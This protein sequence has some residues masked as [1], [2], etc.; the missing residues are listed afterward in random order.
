VGSLEERVAVITGAGRGLGREHARLFASEGARVVV[1][2]LGEVAEETAA[3]IRDAGGQAIASNHDITDWDGGRELIESALSAFGRLDVLVN[4]A[5]TTSFIPHHDLDAVTTETWHT[6]MGVNLIG[7]PRT[8]QGPDTARMEALAR[9]FRPRI[10]FTNSVLHNPT[11]TCI[12]ASV[13]HRVLRIAEEH[14]FFVCE[15][16]V[17]G[18]LHPGP[19]HRIAELDQLRRVVYVGGFSKTLGAGL[20]VG[21]V[22]AEREI[23]KEL[24]H[25]KMLAS[26]ATPEMVERLVE[27]F[28]P[29]RVYLFG[30]AARGDAGPDSDYDLLVV[31]SASDEPG[32]RRMQRAQEALWGIWAAADVF[33]LTRDEFAR[34]QSV[35]TSLASAALAEGRVLYA[36]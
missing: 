10:F 7:V 17:F 32:Y 13:A 33:V 8:Q 15:D 2:D 12:G 5:G 18:D 19:T 3:E 9:E 24:T 16:D 30:S 31:V 29:E 28:H 22:A 25:Q 4:N 6:I 26:L 11:G 14:D 35:A 36:A 23:A 1:N 21:F 27:A 34:Q 20:R